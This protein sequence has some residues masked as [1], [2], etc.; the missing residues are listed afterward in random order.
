MVHG[1]PCTTVERAAF[2]AMRSCAD[3]RAATIAFDMVTAAEL[4]SIRR[5]MRYVLRHGGRPGVRQVREALSLADEHSRSP[6]ESRMRLVWELDA[7]F[8]HPVCN[9]AVYTLTGKLIG[10]PDLLDAQ[11]GVVGEYDG[12]QH[13]LR[14][15]RRRDARRRAAFRSVGLE[16][17]EVVAGDFDDNDLVVERMRGA[18]RR[19][20]WLP[21]ASRGW[22]IMSP[23]DEAPEETLD[24]RLDRRDLAR[25][26]HQRQ[27]ARRS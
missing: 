14:S 16:T 15:R 3:V 26:E 5:M 1:V 12:G 4:T 19:A 6:T 18:R 27:Q 25:E 9:R 2:D 23:Y 11:A 8:P 24:F 20:Q 17:F 13:Q 7:G 22:T 21:H 10:V